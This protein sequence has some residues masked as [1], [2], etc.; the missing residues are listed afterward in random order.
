MIGRL[1]TQGVTRFLRRSF[2]R[3]RWP[4]GLMLFEMSHFMGQCSDIARCCIRES[5]TNT[6]ASVISRRSF[7]PNLS[8][9]K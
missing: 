3:P 4:T 1:V 2:P 9:A 8:A 5:A 6:I 7:D